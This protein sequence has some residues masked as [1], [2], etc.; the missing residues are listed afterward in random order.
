MDKF[1][2]GAIAGFFLCTWALEV[3]SLHAVKV[4][5]EK[6]THALNGGLSPQGTVSDSVYR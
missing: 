5:A 6:T 2:L 4:L 3:P 1:V